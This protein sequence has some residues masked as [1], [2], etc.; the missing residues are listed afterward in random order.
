MIP[1]FLNK[2]KAIFVIVFITLAAVAFQNCARGFSAN[3]E[4][5]ESIPNRLGPMAAYLQAQKLALLGKWQDPCTYSEKW[6]LSYTGQYGFSEKAF[7]YAHF[8]YELS[9][10]K[11][12][13]LGA[14]GSEIK[15]TYNY[16]TGLLD[17]LDSESPLEFDYQ[18]VKIEYIPRIQEVVDD[19]NA[20]A[21][22]GYTNWQLNVAK[23]LVSL[24][25]ECVSAKPNRYEILKVIGN[26]LYGGVLETLDGTSPQKRPQQLDMT[27]PL[28]RLYQDSTK[29]TH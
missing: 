2:I 7:T 14:V 13:C 12:Q 22:C 6:D 28:T 21:F 8:L 24:Q 10:D 19:W 25:N 20:A 4:L 5:N 1:M 18:F 15:L 11:N 23:V 3:S 26:N 29:I 17:P 9:S 27:Y 16:Q